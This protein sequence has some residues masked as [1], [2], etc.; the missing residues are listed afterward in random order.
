MILMRVLMLV[1]LMLLGSHV[2]ICFN[3]WLLTRWVRRLRNM[4]SLLL[5]YILV[6]SLIFVF[7]LWLNRLI[8]VALPN[9]L[10]PVDLVIDV[11]MLLLLCLL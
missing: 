5:D 6:I 11:C 10:I 9:L 2:L 8:D 1:G 3:L 4:L 7:V